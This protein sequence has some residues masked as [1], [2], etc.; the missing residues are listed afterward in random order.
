MFSYPK[1]GFLRGCDP[2]KGGSKKRSFEKRF[3]WSSRGG[4]KGVS[5]D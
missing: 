3:K 5:E 4:R 2:P 1:K